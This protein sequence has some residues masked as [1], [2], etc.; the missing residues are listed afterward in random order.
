MI[1]ERLETWDRCLASLSFVRDYLRGLGADS[2]AGE[3]LLR[4][5]QAFA[6]IF[7]YETKPRAAAVLETHDRYID[8]QMVLAGRERLEWFPRRDLR[9]EKA[10]DAA[11]DATFYVKPAEPAGSILL[12][13][14][15]TVALFPEDGHL[16][17]AQVAGP[18]V[19]KK[20]VVKVALELITGDR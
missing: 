1:I 9:P 7:S 20:V 4:G 6:R 16:T 8:V 2:A 19:V 5:R 18:E 3:H 13:P 15:L 14:G 11:T 17:Q 12:S 10:Y